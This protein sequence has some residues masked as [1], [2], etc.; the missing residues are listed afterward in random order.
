MVLLF[1]V[2]GCVQTNSSNKLIVYT[3]D[4]MVSDYGLGPKISELFKKETGSSVEFVS[5]GD[6]GAMVNKLILEGKNSK[7]DVVLGVDNSLAKKLLN[8][9]LLQETSLSEEL[10]NSIKNYWFESS[11]ELIPFDYG[12]IA[13][14]Y[15]SRLKMSFPKSL[16][17][18]TEPQYKN[19]FILID[20]RTSST[21]KMF[22]KWSASVFPKTELKNYWKKINSNALTIASG[23]SEAYNAFLAGEA[24]MVL[25]YATSP[26]YHVEFENKK[27]IKAL[28][29]DEGHPIQIEYV[30]VLKTSKK[31]ELAKK[32]IELI[33]SEKVQEKIPLTQFMY[34]IKKNTKLPESFKYALKPKKE[35]KISNKQ[36][37]VKEWEKTI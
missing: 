17:E 32:F 15:D 4:S 26:A 24:P 5:V 27:H 1:F 25:S 2:F 21:G 36:D 13:M 19:K 6:A 28:E 11:E 16:K 8:A 23:W 18:L 37:L 22:L 31:Q 9:N 29:F 34:P 14:V 7:A 30:G 12:F 35:I 33:L 3:Y 10:K 20:P